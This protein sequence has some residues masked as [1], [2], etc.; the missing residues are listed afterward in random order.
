MFAAR[1][2]VGHAPLEKNVRGLWVSVLWLN[3]R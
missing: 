3:G 2:E 1:R